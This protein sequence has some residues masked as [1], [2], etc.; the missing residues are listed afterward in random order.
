M[1][2]RKRI[3]AMARDLALEQGKPLA[4]A[5]IEIAVAAEMFEAAAED[6]KRLNGEILPSADTTRQIFVTR[7]PL[8][9]VAVITP[10]NFP[11]TIPSEYLSACLAVGNTVVWKPASTTP[12]SAHHM[13]PASRKRVSRRRPQHCPRLRLHD[14][15]PPRR[16]SIGDRDRPDR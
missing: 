1:A 11:V 2:L 5:R 3:D 4:E 6:G 7:V 16:T 10:W 9:V 12:V 13:A 8:G 15:P 14:R